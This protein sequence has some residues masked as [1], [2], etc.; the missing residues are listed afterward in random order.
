M[1]F[2]SE[3]IGGGVAEPVRAVGGV[4]DALFTSDDERLTRSEALERLRQ[5]PHMAQV[6]LNRVEA[7]HRTIFVAGWRPAIG[8]I[9]AVG[10]AFPFVVNPALQW[11]TGEPGPSMPTDAIY[12][13]IIPMLGLGGLRTAE[14]MAGR[15]R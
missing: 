9:C 7:A 6:E 13:L 14:K 15:T 2:I 4:L 10:L 11:W 8:W 5:R 12:G 1:S 3:L